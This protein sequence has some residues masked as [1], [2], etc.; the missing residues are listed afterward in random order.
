MPK[1][2]EHHTKKE[3]KVNILAELHNKTVKIKNNP[4][5]MLHHTSTMLTIFNK[6]HAKPKI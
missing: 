1:I 2:C 5:K 6:L 4:L 3:Q